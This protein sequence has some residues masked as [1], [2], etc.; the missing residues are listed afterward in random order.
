[1]TPSLP[2]DD[3]VPAVEPANDAKCRS[4]RG[5]GNGL[6]GH[7]NNGRRMAETMSHVACCPCGTR[8]GDRL[9][10][11]NGTRERRLARPP[12]RAAAPVGSDRGDDQV[13]AEACASGQSAF[14]TTVTEWDWLGAGIPALLGRMT[15]SPGFGSSRCAARSVWAPVPARTP[16]PCPAPRGLAPGCRARTGRPAVCR[17]SSRGPTLLRWSRPA[18]RSRPSP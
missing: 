16:S 10:G 13:V 18:P 12:G 11:V 2:R 1:M 3:K 8:R 4:P 9:A 5:R 17:S 15:G 7:R 6:R 14:G